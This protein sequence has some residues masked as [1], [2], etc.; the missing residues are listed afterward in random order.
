MKLAVLGWPVR[1]SLSPRM[2]T[3]ALRAAGLS[4]WTYQ[5]IEVAPEQFADAVQVLREPGWRGVNVTVPHKEAAARLCD[6]LVGDAAAIGAVNTIVVEGGR[7]LGHNTDVAAIRDTLVDVSGR[8]CAVLGAGGSARAAVHALRTRGAGEIR[9]LSR[10]GVLLPGADRACSWSADALAGCQILVGCV[11]PEVE[12]P[13]LER[14]D[15]HALVLD[16]VY[17]R[18]SGLA[19]AAAARG[20]HVDDGL[21][22]LIRQGA[23]SFELWTGRAAPIEAMREAVEDAKDHQLESP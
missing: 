13:P 9:V 6:Q 15:P 18:P 8:T 7:L 21:W 1:H 4:G 3:A 17:Y 12:P 10:R 5:A 19:L 16:L 14:T 23:R 20:L 11:P 22:V 2:Q